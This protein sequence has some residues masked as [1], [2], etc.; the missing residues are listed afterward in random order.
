MNGNLIAMVE[1][2]GNKKCNKKWLN[3]W[4]KEYRV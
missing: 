1:G 4:I 3:L 2:C